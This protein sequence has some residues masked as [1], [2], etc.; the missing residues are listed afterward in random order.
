MQVGKISVLPTER[1]F[2]KA[3]RIIVKTG[4]LPAERSIE[5]KNGIKTGGDI[6]AGRIKNAIQNSIG[7][8][9]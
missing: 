1:K 8:M 5:G 2:K 3:K 9:R 4:I 7:N 6:A